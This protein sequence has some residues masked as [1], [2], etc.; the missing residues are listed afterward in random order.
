MFLPGYLESN[1]AEGVVNGKPLFEESTVLLPYQF[2]PNTSVGFFTPFVTVSILLILIAL[3]TFFIKH[4]V[5]QNIFDGLFFFVLG[6]MGCVFLFMWFGTDHQSCHQ[7]L[8]MLWANPFYLML[9]PM[10]FIKKWKWIWWFVLI[11]TGILLLSFPVF[12]QQY[13]L[14][15]IPLFLMLLIRCFYRIKMH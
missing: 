14:A 4:N 6:I 9:I 7:N 13:H 12:P 3:F 5:L 15:F 11:I 8:N 10:A 2:Q 1:L